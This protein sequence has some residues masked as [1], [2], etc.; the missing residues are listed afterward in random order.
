MESNWYGA[1]TWNGEPNT[2]EL[3]IEVT[4]TKHWDAISRATEPYFA[5]LNFKN[6]SAPPATKNQK[7]CGWH[8][9]MVKKTFT[10]INGSD[11]WRFNQGEEPLH[12][13]WPSHLKLFME[14]YRGTLIGKKFGI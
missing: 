5:S 11:R 7:Y 14:K 12:T 10:R 3:I 1:Y 8:I 2:T 9:D 6:A 4:D 13:A